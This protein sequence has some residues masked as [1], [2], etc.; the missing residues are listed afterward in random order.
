MGAK[1]KFMTPHLISTSNVHYHKTQPFYL[2]KICQAFSKTPPRK[3]AFLQ[4]E[5]LAQ[6]LTRTNSGVSPNLSLP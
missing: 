2:N 5:L 1:D 4:L 3:Q 6:E